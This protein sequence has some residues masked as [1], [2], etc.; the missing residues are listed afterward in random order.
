MKHSLKIRLIYHGANVLLVG[1][2]AGVVLMYAIDDSWGPAAVNAW[3]IAHTSIT[4]TGVAF[5]AMAATFDTLKLGPRAALTLFVSL[6]V[7]AYTFC[8][9]LVIGALAGVVGLA[10][11]GP[12]LNWVVF[13]LF[14]IGAFA[15][16]FGLII[17]IVGARRAI[18]NL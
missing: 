10:P 14:V 2:L 4:L 12:F 9:G 18:R 8:I 7:S 6:M 16:V 17:F 3:R 13:I 1:L 15:V 5:I 11:M